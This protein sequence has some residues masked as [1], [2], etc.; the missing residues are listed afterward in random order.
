[1]RQIRPSRLQA[2]RS[3]P[4][5]ERQEL[6]RAGRQNEQ[7]E[8]PLATRFHRVF[9]HGQERRNSAGQNPARPQEGQG[10]PDTGGAAHN[11]VLHLD[12]VH[13][14]LRPGDG[15]RGR[16]GC[17]SFFGLVTL[18]HARSFLGQK[19]FFSKVAENGFFRHSEQLLGKFF[20][21]SNFFFSC[22]GGT[23]GKN[24]AKKIFFSKIC[25]EL[26]KNALAAMWDVA[27]S[28]CPVVAF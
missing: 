28:F 3:H 8:A 5:A 4:A 20:F 16:H 17:V 22:Q 21:C 15:P 27:I 7:T 12:H 1:M 18:G 9:R 19:K 11:R 6:L 24:W 2:P 14:E 26:H 23:T 13:E 25:L 10:R